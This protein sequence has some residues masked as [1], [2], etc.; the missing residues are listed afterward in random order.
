MSTIVS[1]GLAEKMSWAAGA[2][3]CQCLVPGDVILHCFGG[4]AKLHS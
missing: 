2:A 1:E 3:S 4:K